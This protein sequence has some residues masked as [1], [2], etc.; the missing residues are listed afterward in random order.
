MS[1]SWLLLTNDDG[2]EARPLQMLIVALLARGHKVAV[3]APSENHSATGMKLSLGKPLGVRE[4]TDICSKLSTEKDELYMF[5]LDGTPCD[6]VITALDGGLEKLMSDVEVKMV[7]S[8]INIGPNLSQDTYH[9]G[10]IA[11]AREAGLYG[12]PALACS[13][14]SFNEEGVE[15]AVEATIPIIEA[16][17]AL[18][19][20]KPVNLRRPHVDVSSPHLSD[21]PNESQ[22]AWLKEPVN[23]LRTAFQHGELILNVNVPPEWN[24]K[25]AT[26]RLGMRWYRGAVVLDEDKE[27][28]TFTIGAASID[29]DPVERGDCDADIAGFSSI[30]CLPSWPVMHPLAL[31]ERLLAWCLENSQS[32][33]P[34][35][36]HN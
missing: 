12:M 28:S 29:Y 9:S 13:W 2:I 7:I 16:C 31:D 6:T 32:G 27:T 17:L 36:L 26:T 4:R 14:S 24:G 35:W 15:K 3:L 34:V 8:G 25:Y 11:A 30:T 23:A 18:L 10:T 22:K 33:M 5:E 21:W 19:P 1:D 20:D